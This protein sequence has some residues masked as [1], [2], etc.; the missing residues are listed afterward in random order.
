MSNGEQKTE[1]SVKFGDDAW[2]YCD[3]HLR[4]HM[5]GWCTVSVRNK[6][7]L[8]AKSAEEAYAECKELGFRME[9][10]AK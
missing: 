8:R 3:Q 7:L 1:D 10:S 9:S 4:P 2:V 6:V 5:T